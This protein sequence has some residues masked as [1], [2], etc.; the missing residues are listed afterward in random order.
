MV[1]HDRV[2]LVEGGVEGDRY[3]TGRG[4]YSP[5][6]VCEVTLVAAEALETIRA[7]TGIDLA[8]GRHRRNVVVRG[9]DLDDLLGATFR[10]GD[11]P[12]DD[13]STGDGTPAN[14]GTPASDGAP[15]G[16]STRGS[17]DGTGALLRGTRPRPPCAHVEAVA[18][19]DGVA[20]ALRNRRG[21]ICAEVVEP[22]AVAV[23]DG[24]TVVEGDSRSEGRKIVDRLRDALGG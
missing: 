19:E 2:R 21:G 1:E 9:V 12:R 13:T 17:D 14:D 6:D 10:L 20:A 5:F 11:V 7:E 15:G 3:L 23:G 4:Y 24:L 16:D 8:D 18:G 22:G